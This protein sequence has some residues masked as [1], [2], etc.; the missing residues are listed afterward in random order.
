MIRNK[1]IKKRC[2]KCESANIYKRSRT[3]EQRRIT[4]G[5]Q[6]NIMKKI[7]TCR[8]CNHEFDVPFE[9]LKML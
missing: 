7:Y 4:R 8:Q 9:P 3:L 1:Q 5:K 6:K 2:P